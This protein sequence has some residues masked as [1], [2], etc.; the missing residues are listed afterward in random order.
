[1]ILLFPGSRFSLHPSGALFWVFSDPLH[2]SAVND[3][4][5]GWLGDQAAVRGNSSGGDD[6]NGGVSPRLL[7]R[8]SSMRV[9]GAVWGCS[10][11]LTWLFPPR[12][13]WA[14][15][16]RGLHFLLALVLFDTGL[17]VVLLN[18]CAVFVDGF[19]PTERPFTSTWSTLTTVLAVIPLFIASSLYDVDN[20]TAFELFSAGCGMVCTV[21]FWFFSES[22]EATARHEAD[23][24]AIAGDGAWQQ[25]NQ[26]QQ[27]RRGHLGSG[28]AEIGVGGAE[29]EVVAAD[30]VGS[31]TS[32]V[33]DVEGSSG[34]RRSGDG[35]GVT[36]FARQLLRHR[37]FWLFVAM[38]FLQTLHITVNAN[39]APLCVELL[40][41]RS[42][43]DNSLVTRLVGAA[44][45]SGGV[46]VAPL[47]ALGSSRL[48]SRHGYHTI[49]DG[50]FLGKV[51]LAAAA[52]F[53]VDVL[54][55][56]FGGSSTAGWSAVRATG[57]ALYLMANT[58]VAQAAFSCFNTVLGDVAEEDAFV[59][60]HR[61]APQSAS[62][63]GINAL[64]VKPAVSVAPLLLWYYGFRDQNADGE[65]GDEV[66]HR[67]DAA[68]A[69]GDDG[70]DAALL[71]NFML[72]M[73]CLAGVLQ[74][75]L[76]RR[77]DA[78]VCME[79]FRHKQSVQAAVVDVVVS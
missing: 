24:A 79:K 48:L 19:A 77:F 50:T 33:P 31:P 57:S 51:V 62:Y 46:V 15:W 60:H 35:V 42:D 44:V 26:Q 6:S 73:P 65:R 72:A 68:A 14:D 45:I 30:S 43:G 69:A 67:T 52:Y 58:G 16:A 55:G 2:C 36:Q 17:T 41:G 3:P 74:H 29:S 78:H 38:N 11:A 34:V 32:T 13:G 7:G 49:L 4:I 1:V 75:L 25:Q 53:V 27:Q 61:S 10:F 64:F 66:V 8:L 76:W 12:A 28:V 22:F 40:L 59:L 9:W 70:T 39:A 18:Q 21:A 5:V 47:L 63:F 54:G 71:W 20:L 23:V 37:N 56:G